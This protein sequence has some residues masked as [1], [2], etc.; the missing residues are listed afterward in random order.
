M[1][2]LL[3]CISLGIAL[4]IP[5]K[6]K[7]RLL[8]K[9]L[10]VVND[11]II[12][13]SEVERIRNTITSRRNIIP[14]IYTKARPSRREVID[15]KIR[16]IIVHQ[17]LSEVGYVVSDEEVESS[18]KEREVALGIGRQD[19]INFLK[20]S[21]LSFDEY[22][23]IT[24][25]ALEYGRFNSWIIQPLVSITDQ[26]VKNAFYKENVNNQALGLKYNLVNYSIAKSEITKREL[27]EFTRSLER[28]RKN[29]ILP[30]KFANTQTNNLGYITEDGLEDG[31]RKLLKRTDEG[32]FSQPYTIG[33]R[34]HIF[35]VSKKDLVESE[36][37]QREKGRIK[38]KLFEQTAQKVIDLWFE[39]EKS[40]FYIKY[41]L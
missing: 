21:G 29:G 6:V 27:A 4:S 10:A 3:T 15:I 40:K 2:Q 22:F 20:N 28:F 26:E 33:N 7:A 23:E 13:L 11:Q 25:E 31:L 24:R 16:G 1:L 38:A 12:S 34:Y 5:F 18:I 37:F 17:K 14:Q 32:S 35:Y 39:S 19:L 9:T 36:T 41:F 30:A 8:D